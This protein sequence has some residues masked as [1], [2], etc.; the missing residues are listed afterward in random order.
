LIREAAAEGRT[1]FLSSHVLSEAEALCK[2]IAIIREGRVATVESVEALK[3]RAV[4]RLEIEFASPVPAE[5]FAGLQGVR[6][7]R[8]NG[9]HV[10]FTVAG[11]VDAIVKAAARFSVVDVTSEKPSLEEVFLAY[12]SGDNGQARLQAGYPGAPA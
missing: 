5:T 6:D 8:V 12:Y 7:M 9:T 10:S 3:S 4:R 11:S 2:R 1:V